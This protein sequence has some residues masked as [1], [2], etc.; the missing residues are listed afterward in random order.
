MMLLHA[1]GARTLAAPPVAGQNSL[2]S[3]GAEHTRGSTVTR[4]AIASCC[5][6]DFAPQ[7]PAWAAIEA[8]KPDALL[9]LGDNVYTVQKGWDHKHLDQ[10]YRKQL[11]VP[12]FKSLIRKVPV[13]ATWDDHDFGPN[14]SR[15]AH[16][17]DEKRRRSRE[18]FHEHMAFRIAQNK[19]HVYC[20]TEI[21]DV[22]IIMLDVRYYRTTSNNAN[23][24]LL[25]EE[26]E[27]WLWNEL[28]H[29]RKY[30]LIGSG[31]CVAAG[32]T[33]EKV[34]DFER[35][36]RKLRKRLLARGRVL[37]LSGDLHLNAFRNHKGFYEVTSS[38]VGRTHK[39]GP[40]QGQQMDNY[41][42]IDI[43]PQRVK[44]ALRGNQASNHIDATIR[45]SD[46]S[47]I[48]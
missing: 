34:R 6:V 33:R 38:G 2:S 19:P 11:A 15:G 27:T 30:T 36:Y 1:M 31:T 28:D 32:P 48:A 35:F 14:D 45:S 10:Q 16:V 46:W 3:H 8:A 40:Y 17:A 43:G 13:L 25:G 47:L 22:K 44:V 18:L 12:S 29:Q 4:I 9:L 20:A 23:A 39:D 41:G 42:L 37:W 7:Q 21:D 24:T 5:N 26:Q